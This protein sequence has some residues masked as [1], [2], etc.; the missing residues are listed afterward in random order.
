MRVRPVLI[1]AAV[2]L[3]GA[4]ALVGILARPQTAEQPNAPALLGDTQLREAP[5]Q[6]API[7]TSLAADTPVE[8]LA[9]SDDGYWL[10]VVPQRQRTPRGW[11]PLISVRN[12]GDLAMLPRTV[13]SAMTATASP[14]A[15]S[16][17]AMTPAVSPVATSLQAD[18]RIE[19]LDSRG[20]RLHLV[21]RNMGAVAAPQLLQVTVDD[22]AAREVDLGRELP[23][24]ETAEFVLETEYVQRRASVTVT[25]HVVGDQDAGASTGATATAVVEP[26]EPNDLELLAP[27]ADAGDGHLIVSMRNNSPI[28]LVGTATVSVREPPPS[29]RL[30][31]R[32]DAPFDVEPKVSFDVDF[33]E[34]REPDPAAFYIVLS[35]DALTDADLGNN[36]Y[37][38]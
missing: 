9:V 10:S 20:N 8:L 33:V 30:V 16:A 25:V 31:A 11:V 1:A 36:T 22:R 18:V 32:L 37:P 6:D 21:V 27:S 5:R 13:T 26:D 34:I 14:V 4:A 2:A 38:R 24:G 7:V 35:T 17:T 23:P 29:N 12:T 19:Q 3:T 28:P 15:P